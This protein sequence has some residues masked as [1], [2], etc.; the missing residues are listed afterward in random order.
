MEK[1]WCLDFQNLVTCLTRSGQSL[2]EALGEILTH[3]YGLY[4][5]W[6]RAAASLEAA[7]N[8]PRTNMWDFDDTPTDATDRKVSVFKLLSA[9]DWYLLRTR[10]SSQTKVA[11]SN[12]G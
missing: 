1:S 7:L 10:L 6:R 4:Y 9:H 3:K 8:L 12:C 5:E 2:T 11:S